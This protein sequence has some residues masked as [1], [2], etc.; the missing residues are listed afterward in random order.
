[1][2]IQVLQAQ[3]ME[4]VRTLAPEQA[5]ADLEILASLLDQVHPDPYRYTAKGELDRMV[6]NLRDSLSLPVTMA[7]FRS[8][9]AT[10]FHAIGDARC[11]LEHPQVDVE[12]KLLPLK[13]LVQGEEVLVVDETKGFRS[14]PSGSRIVSINGMPMATVLERIGAYVI[15]D[16]RN[17][18]LRET[19]IG[20]RFPELFHSYVDHGSSFTIVYEGP[21]AVR[22]EVLVMGLTQEEVSRSQKPAGVQLAP[23]TSTIHPGQDALWLSLSTLE[24][25]ELYK[26]DLDPAKYLRALLKEM[27]RKGIRNLVVDVRNADGRELAMAELL[28]S[29]IATE[30]FRVVQDMAVRS[31]EPPTWYAHATAQPEFY[32]TVAGL[33]LPNGS[34]S[35]HVRPDD[36]RLEQIPPMKRAFTGRVHVVCNG[37]TRGA[38]AAFVMLAKRSKR[39]RIVGEEVGTNAGSSTG[40]RSLD[41][42]LPNSGFRF[43]IPLVRYVPDGMCNS[44]LDHGEMPH[45]TVVQRAEHLAKGRDSVKA[46]LLELF[47]EMR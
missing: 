39:A 46:A 9:L 29:F 1:M 31:M 18:T 17:T 36:H 15:T 32:S 5:Q 21:G 42:E 40:G 22:S 33:F 8:S 27:K 10:I 3:P 7:S 6:G 25:E 26:A 43:S 35:Y 12:A 24:Q 16:G 34:G 45:H 23:W 2:A 13:V 20:S 11:Q 14:M 38:A 41:V 37:G 44:P 30:P 4:L 19:I 47:N 28:F